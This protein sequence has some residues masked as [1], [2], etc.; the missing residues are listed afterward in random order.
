MA[1]PGKLVRDLIPEIVERS[2][3]IAVVRQLAHEERLPALL[4]KLQEEADELREAGDAASCSEEL[5]DVFE[6]VLAIAAQLGVAWA[7][8]ERLARDKREERGG[9]EQALWMELS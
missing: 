3:G 4:D 7:E 6:V 8:I 9:F 2:G 5:A 1:M